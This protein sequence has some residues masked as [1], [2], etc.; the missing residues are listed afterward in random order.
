M[1]MTSLRAVMLSWPFLRTPK[2]PVSN[3]PVGSEDL[4][5]E[6]GTVVIAG[7]DHRSLDLQA[8]I[9]PSGTTRCRR[10]RCGCGLGDG[11]ADLDEESA[12]RSSRG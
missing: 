6:L 11:G 8:S 9:V 2:S 1:M 3:Q 12:S 5:V 10:R 4:A 7:G